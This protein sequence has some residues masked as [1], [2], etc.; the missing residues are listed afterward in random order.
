LF[1]R[2]LL[3]YINHGPQAAR[4][5]SDSSIEVSIWLLS[6]LPPALADWSVSQ[7]SA[8]R[9]RSTVARDWQSV[10]A[11]HLAYPF[12]SDSETPERYLPLRATTEQSWRGT[13][14]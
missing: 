14:R 13:N 11:S 2:L 5:W 3:A 6:P 7:R 1:F 8:K 12:S 10:I 4:D 9:V